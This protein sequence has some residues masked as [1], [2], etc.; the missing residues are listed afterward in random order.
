MQNHFA[1]LKRLT[2]VLAALALVLPLLL[3]GGGAGAAEPVDSGLLWL[4]NYDHAIPAEYVPDD[5]KGESAKLR[6]PAY[7]SYQRMLGDMRAA[8]CSAYLTSGYRSYQTQTSLFQSRLDGRR[9]NGMSYDAAFAATRRYT[10]VPGTS[11]HQL[12]LAADLTAGGSLSGSFANTAAG[13]WLYANCARYG[14]IKRYDG[15]KEPLTYVADEAWHFRYVGVPH[16]QLMVEH[17]WCLEEYLAYLR[18]AGTVFLDGEE[19]MVYEIVWSAAPPEFRE[20]AV[21]CSGDNMGGYVATYYHSKDPLTKARGHWSEPY[22]EALFSRGDLPSVGTVD[23]DGPIKRGDFIA[24]YA[25]LTLPRTGE[26][27]P[28][29]DVG[30][31]DP[32]WGAVEKLS[33]SGVLTGGALCPDRLLTRQE[34]AVFAGRML[35]HEQIWLDYADAGSIAGWAFQSVQQVTACG[36]MTGADGLFRPDGQVTWGEAAEMLCRLENV[37]LNGTGPAGTPAKSV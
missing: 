8:G 32:L 6:E 9:R 36:V 21:D 23:P 22:L 1:G 20:D 17:G 34:A 28:C 25:Q 37:V 29:P 33:A 13:R 2:G 30:P 18:E 4:V 24:L 3:C 5:L 7:E 26:A 19:G 31:D 11:E 14:F 35:P 16:A 10:A 15:D 12:G 27:A